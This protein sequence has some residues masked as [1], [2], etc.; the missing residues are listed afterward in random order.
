MNMYL[1]NLNIC[2]FGVTQKYPVNYAAEGALQ[3]HVYSHWKLC[4]VNELK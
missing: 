1:N 3:Q 2:N 4:T